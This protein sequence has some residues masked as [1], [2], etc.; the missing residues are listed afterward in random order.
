MNKNY[1]ESYIWAGKVHRWA[2]PFH[3][4]AVGDRF[5]LSDDGR[6]F[7]KTGTNG[8]YK[9]EGDNHFRTGRNTAVIPERYW[10]RKEGGNELVYL[11]TKNPER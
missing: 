3:H 4:L 6:P 1:V 8:W 10:L 5:K 2:V 7:T 11:D 9:D